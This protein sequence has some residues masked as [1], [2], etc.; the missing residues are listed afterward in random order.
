MFGKFSKGKMIEA[1]PVTIKKVYVEK[2][3]AIL[4]LIF[5]KPLDESPFYKY[6]PSTINNVGVPP[7]LEDPYEQNYVIGKSY[8]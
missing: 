6:W 1:V 8:V 4:R 3:N 7:F 2:C 5:S